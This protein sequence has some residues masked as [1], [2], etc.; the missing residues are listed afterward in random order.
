[1][2]A[3]ALVPDHAIVSTA[4]RTRDTWRLV[5]DALP[6]EPPA[7]FEDRI[8]EA[9]PRDIM[10]AIAKAPKTA[11]SLLVVGH[12][13]GLHDM[14]MLVVG[15]GD[16]E[17]RQSLAERFPTAALAVIDLDIAEWAAIRAGGG[18]L[19]RFITPRAIAEAK[20]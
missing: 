16:A 2:A 8:Y 11:R 1:M 6:H 14:A 15:Q 5:A 4:T 18:R 7:D 13:P 19:E 10:A 9:A 20:G 3:Q 17:M 12:N